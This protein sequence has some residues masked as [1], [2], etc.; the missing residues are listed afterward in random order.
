MWRVEPKKTNTLTTWDGWGWWYLIYTVKAERREH[1]HSIASSSSSHETMFMTFSVCISFACTKCFLRKKKFNKPTKVWL[2]LR[3]CRQ[4]AHAQNPC[5]QSSENLSFVAE[6]VLLLLQEVCFLS[7]YEQGSFITRGQAG[8]TNSHVQTQL[9]KERRSPYTHTHTHT[10]T[11]NDLI[12]TNFV[13]QKIWVPEPAST[14]IAQ[15]EPTTNPRHHPSLPQ[16]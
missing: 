13:G 4:S 9:Q 15:S 2:Q 5:E 12:P 3:V 16:G 8:C 6:S 11:Q 1:L 10:H 14:D 7:L